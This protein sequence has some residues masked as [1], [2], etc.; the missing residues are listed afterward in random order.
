MRAIALLAGFALSGC[1]Y[2]STS[3]L[4]ERTLVISGDGTAFTNMAQVTRT[5]ITRAASE[6]QA[7]GFSHF[8]ILDSENTSRV[9]SYTSPTQTTGSVSGSCMGVFCSAT[10]TATTTGGQTMNFY[11][12]GA[13]VVV[14]F[15]TAQEAAN[16]PGAWSV[17]SVMA[18][19]PPQAK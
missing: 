7:R 11:R 9:S 10:G 12:P 3:M 18:A 1:V 4:D 2:A 15:L 17:A 8:V 14:R 19:N 16:V 5:I 13:D 6:A